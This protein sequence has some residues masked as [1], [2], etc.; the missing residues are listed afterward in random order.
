MAI[1]DYGMGR[2]TTPKEDLTYAVEELRHAIERGEGEIAEFNEQRLKLENRIHNTRERIESYKAAL[3][4]FEHA[5]EVLTR[6][7]ID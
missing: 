1:T 7:A 3:G 4:K 6:K 2:P 5:V